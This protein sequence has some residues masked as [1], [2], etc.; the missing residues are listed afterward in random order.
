MVQDMLWDRNSY[1][2][3]VVVTGPGWAIL[4][5]GRWS[6]GERLSLGKVWDAMFTLS[7]AISWVSKQAQL[8]ASAVSLSDGWQLIAQAITKWCIK[9]K[10]PGHPHLHLPA[11]PLF[12]FCNEDES[13]WEERLL[14]ADKHWEVL[15]HALWV[16]HHGDVHLKK[17]GTATSSNKNS[18]LLQPQHL[19]LHQTMGLRVMEVQCQLPPQY[20]R[21]PIDQGAPGISTVADTTGN[22]EVTWKLICPSS[23]IRTRRMP[24][25]TKVGIEIQWCIIKQGAGTT[26][27]FPT[28]F[29]PYR[30]TWGSWWGSWPLTSLL[31]AWLLCWMSTTTMS[32][33]WT[34]WTRSFSNYERPIR[35]WYQIGQCI[36][37]GTSKSLQPHSQ[38]GF[39]QIK[40]LNWN[41]TASVV[42]YLSG[43]R[44]WW[45]T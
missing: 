42:G 12:S 38:K 9:A 1:L 21:G 25:P 20:H 16:P 6:P 37:W 31:M 29:A 40:L 44:W 28:W 33:L 10:G 3:E 36:T 4:F 5:Y 39:H 32:R 35:K 24:S 7:G 30:V 14:S 22:L 45:P 17:A 34:P 2:M 27:S 15:R 11:L 43:W 41:E 13:S 26:P 18:G 8:N 23:R 19:H